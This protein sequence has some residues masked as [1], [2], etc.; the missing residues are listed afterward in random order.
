V[1]TLDS[2][3]TSVGV[4]LTHL[5]N[6]G[7]TQSDDVT[8]KKAA[9]VFL[10]NVK[11]LLGKHTVVI[12]DKYVLA[13]DLFDGQLNHATEIIIFDNIVNNSAKLPGNLTLLR[14]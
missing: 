2:G 3:K 13:F 14:I 12:A 5:F 10:Q 8:V 1:L 4:A 7:H 11:D 9:P 6:F